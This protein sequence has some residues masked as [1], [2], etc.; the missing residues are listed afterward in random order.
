MAKVAVVTGASSG[1]G[2]AVAKALAAAGHDLLLVARDEGRLAEVKQACLDAGADRAVVL[3]AD[4]RE[5][6]AL[7]AVVMTGVREF[8]GFDVLVN[9]AGVGRVAA[10][11]DVGDDEFDDT[12]A[13]NLRAPYLLTAAAIRVMRRR[14]GG[15]IVQIGSGLAHWG[16][17][18]WSLYAATKFALRGFTDCVRH[19]VAGEGIKVGLVSPGY[20]RTEFFGDEGPPWPD[21]GLEPEDVAHAVMAMVQQGSASDMKVIQVRPSASP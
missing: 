10:I 4:L 13:I 18:Q 8:G 16:R 6:K 14:G 7:D 2:A 20:T 19:E 1:I 15:Q 21:E 3:S 5:L 9:N 12:I 17:A 11:E